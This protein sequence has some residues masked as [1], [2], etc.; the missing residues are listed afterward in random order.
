MVVSSSLHSWFWA[1]VT[2]FGRR[3][4]PGDLSKTSFNHLMET[5]KTG[6][7][8]WFHQA[9]RATYLFPSW[10]CG[11]C[12]ASSKQLTG[13]S[14][15]KYYISISCIFYQKSWD[16]RAVSWDVMPLSKAYNWWPTRWAWGKPNPSWR[17][18]R[19]WLRRSQRSIG[20]QSDVGAVQVALVEDQ[21]KRGWV[22]S[23]MQVMTYKNATQL[24]SVGCHF[25]IP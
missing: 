19:R 7:A 22:G 20:I 8:I 3:K 15:K 12:L 10:F 9:H 13:S 24:S 18:R 16:L 25:F 6:F 11:H 17:R 21:T 23:G 4:W 1:Q 5:A 14:W 2:P